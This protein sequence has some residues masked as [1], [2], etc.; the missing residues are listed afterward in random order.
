MT[1]CSISAASDP[2]QILCNL[3]VHGRAICVGIGMLSKA[4]EVRGSITSLVLA[5]G[6]LYKLELDRPPCLTLQSCLLLRE[7]AA[8][9]R[10]GAIIV[11]L[12]PSVSI[13][14]WGEGELP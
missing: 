14:H 8:R 11:Y 6:G 7:Y 2:I 4:V 5:P 10:K 3:I 9:R 12:S 1:R 13:Y